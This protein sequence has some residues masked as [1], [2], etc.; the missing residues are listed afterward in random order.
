MAS[1]LS[2]APVLD[3]SGGAAKSEAASLGMEQR[4]LRVGVIG[5]GEFAQVCHVPGIQSHPNGEVVALCGSDH[6]RVRLI[7]DRLGVRDVHINYGELCARDDVDAVTI[8]TPNRF[9]AEQALCALRYGKNVFCEKPLAVSVGQAREMAGAAVASKKIH[10]V[11]FIF[12]YGFAVREL[13]RRLQSGEIGQPYYL[14]IQYDSW[15]GLQSDF[16]TSWRDK[17]DFAGAGVLFNLGS[18]L[19]DIARYVLGP[20]DSVTGFVHNLPRLRPHAVTG[21]LSMVETDDIAA[22]WFRS[23]GGVRGQWFIG[24]V[25]PPFAERGYLEVIGPEGALKAGLSRGSVD[26][27]K[28]SRPSRPE[29]ED[30][31]LPDEARDGNP[32]S[33][34]LMMHSFV[35]ACLCGELNNEIDASFADGLAAQ[36][37]MAAVIEADRSMKWVSLQ[38]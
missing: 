22:A 35:D 2:L 16:R 1:A 15:G 17:R 13:R 32:H 21:E 30:L 20:L 3:A 34:K 12:R 8:V 31:P 6:Q 18:H 26:I 7:A 23:E 33:L 37:A 36:E 29:W 4:K 9:H 5:T 24:R 28:M 27:L 38:D 14:R 10:Q 11:A 19:F 25:T